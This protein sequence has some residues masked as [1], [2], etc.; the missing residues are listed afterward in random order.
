MSVGLPGSGIGGVFYLLSALWM[1]VH[2]THRTI[3]G[4][5]SRMRV[6]LRQSIMATLILSALWGTGFLIDVLISG[7]Q[8]AAS[9]REAFIPGGD[10]KVPHVFQAAS[11]LLTFGTLAGVLLIVQLLRFVVPQRRVAAPQPRLEDN[12]RKA[13]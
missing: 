7:P 5:H 1:P 11:F 12:D 3:R 8:T 4:N 6:V 13:A 9:L 2:N 10:S